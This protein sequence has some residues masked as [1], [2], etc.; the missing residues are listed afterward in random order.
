[1]T[2]AEAQATENSGFGLAFTLLRLV[3]EFSPRRVE[4]AMQFSV[5]GVNFGDAIF[6]R[7]AAFGQRAQ[8]IMQL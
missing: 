4:A 3:R 6:E 8:Q 1:L 7:V 5:C 2:W